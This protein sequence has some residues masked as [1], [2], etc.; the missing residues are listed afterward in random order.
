[1]IL[2]HSCVEVP[3]EEEGSNEGQ[4][5]VGV[6]KTHVFSAVSI[7]LLVK[8]AGFVMHKLDLLQ[9]TRDKYA[10]LAFLASEN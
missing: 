9:E 5:L 4:G 7:C 8:Q 3:N 10:L 2:L 1:M 6:I